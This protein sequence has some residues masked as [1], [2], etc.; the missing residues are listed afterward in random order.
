[1]KLRWCLMR[2]LRLGLLIRRGISVSVEVLALRLPCTTLL[3]RVLLLIVRRRLMLV[4]LLRLDWLL[5]LRF[6][7]V[8]W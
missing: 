7:C 3:L 2:V 4:G 5:R 1:M 6:G 8:I